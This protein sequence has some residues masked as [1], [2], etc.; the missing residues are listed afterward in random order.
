MFL[1]TPS[2][3]SAK[4]PAG[5]NSSWTEAFGT[6]WIQPGGGIH[7]V[8]HWPAGLPFHLN[9]EGLEEAQ[10]SYQCLSVL[11]SFSV[12]SLLFFLRPVNSLNGFVTKAAKRQAVRPC[13]EEQAFQSQFKFEE[14]ERVECAGHCFPLSS[15][16]KEQKCFICTPVIPITFHFD[17]QSPVH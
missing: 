7:L 10:P 6:T 3:A 11:L 15:R 14:E 9:N 12:C 5:E 16:G 17:Y 4:F 8:P 1:S 2:A 13:N